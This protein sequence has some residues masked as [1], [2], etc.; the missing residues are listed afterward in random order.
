LLVLAAQQGAQ[1]AVM[2][3]LPLLQDQQQAHD[4]GRAA[5]CRSPAC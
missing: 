3:D 5:R 1:F 4:E 2:A